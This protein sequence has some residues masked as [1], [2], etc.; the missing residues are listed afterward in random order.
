MAKKSEEKLRYSDKDLQEFEDIINMKLKDAQEDLIL[1]ENQLSHKDDNSAKDTV[2]TFNMMEDGS[3]VMS[4]EAMSNMAYRQ[5]KFIQHLKS[6]LQRI[7]NKTYGI[8][9]ETG[10]LI[11]KERLKIVPHATLSIEAKKARD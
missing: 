2:H 4:R 6:A 1:M 5:Q 11:A 9:R 8:C 7:H 3:E 10:K